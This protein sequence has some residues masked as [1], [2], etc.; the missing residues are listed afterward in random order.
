MSLSWLR[1]AAYQVLS[2]QLPLSALDRTIEIKLPPNAWASV[3]LAVR[4]LLWFAAE[5][6][7]VGETLPSFNL[8]VGRGFVMPVRAVGRFHSKSGRWV[9]GLQPRLDGGP[10]LEWQMQ[11]W[12]A[13]L[14]E[15]YCTDPLAQAVPLVL[16]VGRDRVTGRRGFHPIDT[17]V[18][19]LIDRDELNF[20]M[21]RFI[22]CYLRAKELVPVRPRRPRRG[23]V[24]PRDPHLP[25]LEPQS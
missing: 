4:S 10:N 24:A 13:L 2:G 19:P 17:S 1:R 11:T 16:D 21:N 7:W 25:G 20:R 9:V 18:V 6:A 3:K 12:L 15:A 22:D 23:P 5:K 14:N 8:E